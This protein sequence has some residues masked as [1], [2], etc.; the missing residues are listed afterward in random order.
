VPDLGPI[1]DA[2]EALGRF[3]V[4]KQLEQ[5]REQT[6]DLL[7]GGGTLLERLVQMLSGGFIEWLVRAVLLLAGV[8]A[9]TLLLAFGPQAE[10]LRGML[11][12]VPPELTTGV[13][14]VQ[15]MTRSVQ[16]IAFLLLPL[17]VAWSGFGY[18]FSFTDG[19]SEGFAKRLVGGGILV[20][21]LPFLLEI[22]FGVVHQ[23]GTAIAGTGDVVPGYA[24]ISEAVTEGIVVAA[25]VTPPVAGPPGSALSESMLDLASHD[26]IAAGALAFVYA[27]ALVFGGAAAAARIAVLDGLYVLSP[28]VALALVTPIGAAIFAAWGRALLTCL[29]VILPAGV[30]LKLA[31]ALM[32][33][34]AQGGP[35][36]V[37]L[38][39]V[40]AVGAYA[41]LVGRAS[42][43]LAFSAPS[44][45][46]R[47]V[48]V[49]GGR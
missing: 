1:S 8:T 10:F 40:A 17:A 30:I 22:A 42:F 49:V 7:T 44:M 41:A 26:S 39:G 27:G 5:S 34:V 13:P 14:E 11:V 48:T 36:W 45:A 6:G 32:L 9:R 29:L 43:G 21:A 28:L 12:G 33:R 15:M 16:V 24:S 4:E 2:L 37:V 38:F 31:A 20:G 46:R 35:L 18:M 23:L 3:L 47:I 19:G 25:A